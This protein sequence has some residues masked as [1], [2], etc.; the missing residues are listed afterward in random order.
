MWSRCDL[1]NV[2]AEQH[3]SG[4][5]GMRRGQLT[6]AAWVLIDGHGAILPLQA[7]TCWR[8][9]GR[10]FKRGNIFVEGAA[11]DR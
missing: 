7:T 2:A 8:Y 5:W 3:P 4:R 10:E 1:L 6:K 9:G 11:L